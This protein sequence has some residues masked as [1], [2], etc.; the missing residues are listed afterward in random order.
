MANETANRSHAAL[1]LQVFEDPDLD[2]IVLAAWGVD[3][4]TLQK[5]G[6]GFYVARL[7]QPL[8]L[9]ID[10]TD[11]TKARFD[12]VVTAQGLALPNF[13]EGF[14][15][16]DPFQGAPPPAG[17]GAGQSIPFSWLSVRTVA[18]PSTEVDVDAMINL[19]V[20]RVPGERR[21]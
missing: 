2:P 6:T 13:A 16:P 20:R 18:I 10:T 5:L 19:E 9:T 4:G 21:R 17:P 1:V 11:P 7:T 3:V 12:F 14:V 15:I 8:G